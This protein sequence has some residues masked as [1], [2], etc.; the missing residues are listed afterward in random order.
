VVVAF[1][2]ILEL[3][4]ESLLKIDQQSAFAPIF[5]EGETFV[6]S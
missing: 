2:A 3:A 5:I 4:K 1:L 6:E